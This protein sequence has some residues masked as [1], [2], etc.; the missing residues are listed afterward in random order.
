MKQNIRIDRRFA[1]IDEWILDLDISDRA[2]RLYAVL[3]RY[4]DKDTHKAFPSRKT[5]AQRLRCSPASVDRASIELVEAGLLAKEHRFN[6]SIV[7]TLITSS[8]VQTPII[9]D[10]ETLSS[11]VSRPIITDDDLTRTTELE[12]V[13]QKPITNKK[14]MIADEYEPSKEVLEKLGNEFP[15]V[16]LDVELEKF[17]DHHM[18][19]GSRFSL[20]DRAFRRWIAQASEWSPQARAARA[21]AEYEKAM[22]EENPNEW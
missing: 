9:T 16:R 18:A 2:I 6:N 13:E 5:L 1:I 19:K 11:P 3:A 14:A 12:P 7:Y 17:R 15:G 4:A 10:D 20:W 8:P 22:E 21:W